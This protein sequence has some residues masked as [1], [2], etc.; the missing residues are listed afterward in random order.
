MFKVR[1]I[2]L[3]SLPMIQI[4][5]VNLERW[6]LDWESIYYSRN[7]CICGQISKLEMNAYIIFLFTI[8]LAFLVMDIKPKPLLQQKLQPQF[9][10]WSSSMKIFNER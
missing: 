7:V 8:N 10:I 6:S 9:L 3:P 2:L 4:I 1:K 5:A